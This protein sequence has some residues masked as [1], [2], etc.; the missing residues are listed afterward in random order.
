MA[1]PIDH[2]FRIDGVYIYKYADDESWGVT[3]QSDG[4]YKPY[5]RG[6]FDKLVEVVTTQKVSRAYAVIV[7]RENKNYIRPSQGEANN[8]PPLTGLVETVTGELF[9]IIN[10]YKDK[11]RHQNE[12][13]LLTLISQRHDES[14]WECERKK[15]TTPSRLLVKDNGNTIM[16]SALDMFNKEFTREYN[17]MQ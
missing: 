17:F 11:W 13:E 16:Y 4:T 12:G 1:F 6:F 7:I 5:K 3:K 15:M 9:S 10:T 14:I 8:Y 2:P